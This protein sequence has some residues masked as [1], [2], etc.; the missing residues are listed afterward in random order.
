MWRCKYKEGDK[1]SKGISSRPRDPTFRFAPTIPSTTRSIVRAFPSQSKRDKEDREKQNRG[2]L[3]LHLSD[4]HEKSPSRSAAGTFYILPTLFRAWT[5]PSRPLFQH[6]DGRR[7][8][9]STTSFLHVVPSPPSMGPPSRGS[10]ERPSHPVP[11]VGGPGLTGVG[12]MVPGLG[13]TWCGGRIGASA[14]LWRTCWAPCAS[15]RAVER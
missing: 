6:V 15:L 5:D 14:W 13:G 1:M 4:S 3:V 10:D 8:L 12:F 11:Q 2:P 9:T 7:F